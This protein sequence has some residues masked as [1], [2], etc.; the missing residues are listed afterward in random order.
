MAQ[1]SSVDIARPWRTHPRETVG[2][3]LLGPAAAIALTGAAG[4]TNR[5]AIDGSRAEAAVPVLPDVNAIRPVAA[6]TAL[7]INSQQP[8]AMGP[9]PSALPFSYAAAG[10]ESRERARQVDPFG[11]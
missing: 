4:S 8:F 3:G 7:Q 11:D 5:L 9:N 10:A 6:D 1:T 2:L